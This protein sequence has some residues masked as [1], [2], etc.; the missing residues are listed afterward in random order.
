MESPLTVF[1][2]VSG[3]NEEYEEV[4]RVPSHYKPLDTFKL[5][6]GTGRQYQQQYGDM[7][8]LRL[9]RLKPAVESLAAT[10]WDGFSVRITRSRRIH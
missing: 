4:Q 8:F 10:A 9:A 1:F 5:P 3:S 2:S 6:A 7:Y